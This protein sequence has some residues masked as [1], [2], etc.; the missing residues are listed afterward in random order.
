MNLIACILPYIYF[1]TKAYGTHGQ[2]QFP[3]HWNPSGRKEQSFVHMGGSA[4]YWLFPTCIPVV[5][6]RNML[7]YTNKRVTTKNGTD[8]VMHTPCQAQLPTPRSKS[9]CSFLLGA[10]A[11]L[12]QGLT[13]LAHSMNLCP[14]LR[15]ALSFRITNICSASHKYVLTCWLSDARH[16]NY[17]VTATRST[18]FACIFLSYKWR[19]SPGC[20]NQAGYCFWI[21]IVRL[22]VPWFFAC[23]RQQATMRKKTRTKHSNI[24]FHADLAV[25][26][27]PIS[28]EDK[29]YDLT[30]LPQ[31]LVF[32]SNFCAPV[33]RS[34][35]LKGNRDCTSNLKEADDKSWRTRHTIGN[36]H[37]MLCRK[38]G[39]V[40]TRPWPKTCDKHA[41]AADFIFLAA[42]QKLASNFS[43]KISEAKIW[44]PK[45]CM[46][47]D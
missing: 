34:H 2:C 31:R 36:T 23:L 29:L 18:A 1:G 14:N 7:A 22:H 5:Y 11:V 39:Y 45:L 27:A 42:P 24:S 21:F 35:A 6:H 26:G 13:M 40:H 15:T 3:T 10:R 47:A 8:L 32:R 37:H 33:H 19:K 20:A 30:K 44:V 4:C 12:C 46:G 38:A 43:I 17:A 25:N 41:A 9:T 16:T 28:T